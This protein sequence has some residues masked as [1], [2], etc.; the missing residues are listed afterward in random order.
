[1][2]IPTAGETKAYI[3]SV[4]EERDRDFFFSAKLLKK[5]GVAAWPPA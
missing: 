4:L 5:K 2:V 3:E 1:M